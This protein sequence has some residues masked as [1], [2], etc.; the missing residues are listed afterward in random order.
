MENEG[1]KEPKVPPEKSSAS[2]AYS[3]CMIKMLRKG[4]WLT[5]EQYDRI[6][7]VIDDYYQI[8]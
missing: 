6:E 2:Y 8:I 7:K 1:R 4:E 5:Q 3:L